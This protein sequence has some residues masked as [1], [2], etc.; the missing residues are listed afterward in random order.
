LQARF[1]DVEYLIVDA[2]PVTN[3]KVVTRKKH[4]RKVRGWNLELTKIAFDEIAG[5]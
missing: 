5:I 3:R 4:E 1:K 2:S